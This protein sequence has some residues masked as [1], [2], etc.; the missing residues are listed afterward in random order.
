LNEK[1]KGILADT[2][3]WIEFFRTRSKT[4]DLLES[5]IKE[6][7]VW[8]CGTVLFEIL[9]GVRTE[10]EKAN[11]LEMLSDLPYIEMSQPLWQKASEISASLRKNGLNLPL[12]DILIAAV[13]I[14]N[15][16]SV[17]TLDKHFEQIPGL[18][19]YRS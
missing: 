11:V 16:F 1:A 6:G 10:E 9:Q 4:G 14:R 12:S 8:L 15:N 17:F 5:L 3:V 2:T 18:K 7:S 19:I 13:A